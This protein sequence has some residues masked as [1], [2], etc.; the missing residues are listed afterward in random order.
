M[1]TVL[2]SMEELQRMAD[3]LAQGGGDWLAPE[4]FAAES[5]PFLARIEAYA[6]REVVE[7]VDYVTSKLDEVRAH[8]R[9]LLRTA[10]DGDN[11][12]HRLAV[13]RTLGTVYRSLRNPASLEREMEDD[14]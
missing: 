4:R 7:H 13:H 5:E 1:E 14:A 10:P 12:R 8:L 2:H 6:E 9:Q 11:E 3:A